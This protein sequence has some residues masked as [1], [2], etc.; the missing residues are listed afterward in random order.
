[1]SA[2]TR[3]ESHNTSRRPGIRWRR[4]IAAYS[5]L[6]L[7]AFGAVALGGCMFQERLIFPSHFAGSPTGYVP[8]DVSQ[9][10]IQHADPSHPTSNQPAARTE[11][12]WSLGAGRT[13]DSPGPAVIYFH[14]NGEILEEIDPRKRTMYTS[15]GVSIAMM[16]YRG[17]GNA[18]GKPGQRRIGADA[19][20]LLE[21]VQARPEVD[22]DRLIFHGRSLGGGV[23]AQL[24]AHSPPAALILETTFTS[25]LAM[26]RRY[27]VPAAWVRHPFRTDHVI[28]HTYSGPVLVFH[29]DADGIIPVQHGRRLAEIAPDRTRYIETVGDG[30]NDFPRDFPAFEAAVGEWLH[31]IGVLPAAQAS[32][33][34]DTL[35]DEPPSE[36]EPNDPR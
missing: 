5:V 7:A 23:A 31:H 32:T 21:L 22:P 20:R 8:P 26:A 29:G 6:L 12:W 35:S 4:R 25:V 16:E 10:W 13:P 33:E 36:P 14:G 28:D 27:L 19:E 15:R 1:M 30:H 2:H 11:V 34:T 18:D 3:N 9:W 24:A 17:Y